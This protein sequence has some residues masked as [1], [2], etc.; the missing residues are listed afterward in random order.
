MPTNRPFLPCGSFHDQKRGQ[1]AKK[2]ATT[3]AQQLSSKD[4]Q[5]WKACKTKSGGHAIVRVA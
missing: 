4:G 5:K 3:L 2:Q 1:T